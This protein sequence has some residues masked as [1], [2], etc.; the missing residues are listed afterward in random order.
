MT[1]YIQENVEAFDSKNLDKRCNFVLVHYLLGTTDNP[2]SLRRT[3]IYIR[4]GE[5]ILNQSLA[6]YQNRTSNTDTIE[7]HKK[8]LLEYIQYLDRDNTFLKLIVDNLIKKD[9]S[10]QMKASLSIDATDKVFFSEPSKENTEK[11]WTIGKKFADALAPVEMIEKFFNQVYQMNLIDDKNNNWTD[12]FKILKSLVFGKI[13]ELQDLSFDDYGILSEKINR[14]W[15]ALSSI[16]SAL[17][18][19]K[20]ASTPITEGQDYSYDIFSFTKKGTEQSLETFV[21]ISSPKV[22]DNKDCNDIQIELNS[23]AERVFSNIEN[24]RNSEKDTIPKIQQHIPYDRDNE[25]MWSNLEVILKQIFYRKDVVLIKIIQWMIILLTNLI[26]KKHEGKTIDFFFVCGDL[27]QFDD[28]KMYKE[29]PKLEGFKAPSINNNFMEVAKHLAKEISDEHYTW[30]ENGRYGLFWNTESKETFP[31]GLVSIKNFT[32]L[33]VL[34]N[35]SKEKLP[36]K[37]PNCFITYVYGNAKRVGSVGIIENKVTD[38]L[39]FYDKRWIEYNSTSPRKDGIINK[40]NEL[41]PSSFKAHTLDET[42]EL[43][44]QIADNPDKGGTLVFVKP[45][46]DMKYFKQMG[47]S[48][49]PSGEKLPEDILALISQ[50]GATLRVLEDDLWKYKYRHFLIPSAKTVELLEQIKNICDH[51]KWPLRAKG[52]RRWS[53]AIIACHMDV[54][55][56]IVISQDGD[57]QLWCIKNKSYTLQKN[58]IEV[59]EFPI[60]GGSNLLIKYPSN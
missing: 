58:K 40:I 36:I 26:A 4:D 25:I 2:Y 3:K 37:I 41:Y 20:A 18:Y 34:K 56:V 10:S 54:D 9:A 31:I 46:A 38:I 44:L 43:A 47:E 48:W 27:S 16:Q 52:S 14:T 17:I 50:D 57:I 60:E 8:A 42:V 33:D 21:I 19:S 24:Q 1:D 39:L 22:Q 29:V 49:E 13:S 5:S 30:F 11:N 12:T 23:E 15:N 6:I 35:R 53:A 45:K 28:E 7:N 59:I 32:W 51:H 55:A